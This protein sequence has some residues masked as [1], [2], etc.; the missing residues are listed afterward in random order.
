MLVTSNFPS[1][2]L[3]HP[4][5]TSNLFFRLF[6]HYLALNQFAEFNLFK[7]SPR[8]MDLPV[9]HLRAETKPLERRSAC[10]QILC[11]LKID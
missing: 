2:N 4:A 3:V 5:N 1:T 10:I 6:P 9:L 8:V 11:A 7:F